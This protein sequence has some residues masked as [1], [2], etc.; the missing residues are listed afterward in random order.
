[1]S[2]NK[3]VTLNR[4]LKASWIVAALRL[5]ASSS[6]LETAKAELEALI[7]QD[8]QGKESIRKSLRYLR[9]LWL[10]PHPEHGDLQNE[11]IG[12]YKEHPTFGNACFLSYFMLITI[13]P[14]AREVAEVC[15]QLNRLQGTV[16]TEQ[17][18]RKI[19]GIH[20]ERE[21][22]LRSARCVVFAFVELGML[23]TAD[24]KGVY[25]A[26]KVALN[27]YRSAAFALNALL[28]S[29]G[30]KSD[31]GRSELEGHPGFFAFDAHALVEQA[32]HDRK[33]I[34]SRESMSRE[35][36]TK[37]SCRDAAPEPRL[38]QV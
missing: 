25:F 20:G 5:R 18:K 15:G 10:E 9:Q 21:Q 19:A 16:K 22:V 12:L 2:S 28:C 14:F 3:S 30:G 38:M 6:D 13:Y 31:V 8:I 35:I 27:G 29:L 17:I 26:A 32:I 24:K 33:F 11:A 37:V 36:I 23:Q 34:I 7:G 4:S 1:M